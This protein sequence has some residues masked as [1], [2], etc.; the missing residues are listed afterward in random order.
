MKNLSSM[1]LLALIC[2]TMIPES[3]QAADNNGHFAIWGKGNKSCHSYNISRNTDEEQ[4]FKDYIMGYL[5][6][7]NVQMPE[8]YRIS[9][10]MKLDE[11]LTWLDDYCQ[12]KP[13]IAFEQSLAD[14]II[15][16]HNERMQRSPSKYRR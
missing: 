9:G 6:A 15:E 7:F 16:N 10:N 13:I 5:T 11:I 2:V 12:L 1:I 14:F 8:T 3:S 4:R